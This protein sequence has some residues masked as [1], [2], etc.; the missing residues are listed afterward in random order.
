[1][2]WGWMIHEGNLEFLSC[3]VKKKRRTLERLEVYP[4]SA[5]VVNLKSWHGS[6][7]VHGTTPSE[8]SRTGGGYPG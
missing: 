5:Q 2:G 8:L 4:V 1:V 3:F 7:R 6:I